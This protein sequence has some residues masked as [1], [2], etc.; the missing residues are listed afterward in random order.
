[1]RARL[2][3]EGVLPLQPSAPHDEAGLTE[4]AHQVTKDQQ[5]PDVQDAAHMRAPAPSV[6]PKPAQGHPKHQP[7]A[8]ARRTSQPIH[9]SHG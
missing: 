7:R 6:L 4:K 5:P 2:R 1:M 9:G 8:N 3:P